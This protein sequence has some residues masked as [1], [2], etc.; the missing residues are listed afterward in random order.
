MTLVNTACVIETDKTGRYAHGL[1]QEKSQL[2]LHTWRHE[3]L[4]N[5][6]STR[7]HDDVTGRS[8]LQ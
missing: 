4:N 7:R 6:L 8:E 3:E 5:M 2:A 1:E